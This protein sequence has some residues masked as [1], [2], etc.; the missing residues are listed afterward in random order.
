MSDRE[1]ENE[2]TDDFVDAMELIWGEGFLSPGGK[3]ELALFLE[4]IELSGRSVLDVGCGIGGCDMA[5]VTD[6]GAGHVL[7]IDIEQPLVDRATARAADAG[8]SDRLSFR[9]VDPGPFPLENE[10]FDVVFSKD[11][12]IHIEDKHALF[13]EVFRVLRPGGRFI[14]SDW[15]RR[16]EE[17]PGPEI[18]RWLDIVG[19]TF[20]QHSPPYYLDALEEA[21]FVE[22]AHTDRNAF[23]RRRLKADHD[24]MTGHAREELVRRTGTAMADHYTEVWHAALKAAECGELRAGHLRGTKPSR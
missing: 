10:S 16:D 22:V 18:Q 5:L 19:L 3:D 1:H 15:M 12:M 4:G 13:R 14:A 7:G 8:L 9:R 6:F 11:A 23:L 2:Y 20:G 24:M 21:G 17:K